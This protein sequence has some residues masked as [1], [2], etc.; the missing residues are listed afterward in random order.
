M[1]SKRFYFYL[2]LIL[3][4]SC[5]S[6]SHKIVST[7]RGNIPFQNESVRLLFTGFYRYEKEQK[8]IEGILIQS[9]F[10]HSEISQKTIEIILQQKE[11]EYPYP[12]FHKINW[13]FTL[14]SAGMFPYHI[15]SENTV[16]FRY[17]DSDKIV[18]EVTYDL[19]MDQIRGILLFPFT[20]FFWPGAVFAHQI[21]ETTNME[22]NN[23]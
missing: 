17:S 15:R 23:F 18:R 19:K 2:F 20:P 4:I 5:A 8:K 12:T 7:N 6:F 22:K 1:F 21:E 9:G 16:T 11:T 10:T 14:L 3:N 13:L